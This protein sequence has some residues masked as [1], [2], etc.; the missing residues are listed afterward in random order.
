MLHLRLQ[1]GTVN[2]VSCG[3]VLL[4]YLRPLV[5]GE[6]VLELKVPQT[7]E[8]A[9]HANCRDPIFPGVTGMEHVKEDRDGHLEALTAAFITYRFFVHLGEGISS[10]RSCELPFLVITASMLC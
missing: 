6:Q 5:V 2:H 8:D 4:D 10:R 7:L 9:S 3:G 1:S